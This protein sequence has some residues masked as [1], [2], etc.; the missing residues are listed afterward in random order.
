[1]Y[2][3]MERFTTNSIITLNKLGLFLIKSFERRNAVVNN[4]TYN[5][6]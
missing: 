1:M 2:K 5:D 4:Q 3:F 6:V